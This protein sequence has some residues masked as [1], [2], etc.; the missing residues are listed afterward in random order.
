MSLDLSSIK[1]LSSINLE[2]SI[3]SD[4]NSFKRNSSKIIVEKLIKN[5]KKKTTFQEIYR[6]T[7][8]KLFQS[9]TKTTKDNTFSLNSQ[10]SINN[11]KKYEKYLN[12]RNSD[13]SPEEIEKKL[14][15]EKEDDII[16][17]KKVLYNYKLKKNNN[18]IKINDLRKYIIKIE[19]KIKDEEKTLYNLNVSNFMK[20]IYDLFSR[21]SFI[22]FV[23]IKNKKLEQAKEIFSLMLK[24]NMKYID[25]IE[26]EII[27]TYSSSKN[28]PQE[29]Y[30]L[31]IIYSFIIKYSRYFNINYKCNIFLSRYLEIIYYIYNWFK[32][33]INIRNLVF[34]SKNQINYKI[35]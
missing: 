30:E 28:F 29:T 22:I 13:A 34:E 33:K 8:K 32:Y 1:S 24:E 19:K 2:D 11:T 3:I 7:E 31:L 35:K 17:L 10:S 5:Y 4:K 18:I 9:K 20:K 12:K 16:F 14:N 27:K 6:N 23:L 26:K 21:F 25:Y 15:K